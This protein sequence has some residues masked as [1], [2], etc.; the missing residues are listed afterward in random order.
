MEYSECEK[1]GKVKDQSQAIGEFIDWLQSEKG[2]VF[3]RYHIEGKDPIVDYLKKLI[4]VHLSME[5]TLAEFFDIDLN[6]VEEERR[7]MLDDLRKRD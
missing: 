2:I 1:I 3:A 5:K 4:P 6:K 7:A